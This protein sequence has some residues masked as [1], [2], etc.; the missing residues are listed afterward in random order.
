MEENP[1]VLLDET[2]TVLDESIIWTRNYRNTFG[3]IQHCELCGAFSLE[4]QHH[5]TLQRHLF[6]HLRFNPR[7]I[8]K[9]CKSCHE[10]CH[11]EDD[12]RQFNRILQNRIKVSERNK[13]TFSKT[14]TSRE[15]LEREIS[16]LKHRM[17]RM[18]ERMSKLEQ[19]RGKLYL[20][21]LYA[22]KIQKMQEFISSNFPQFT[23]PEEWKIH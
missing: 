14:R 9:I 7:F 2:H 1:E 3:I 8:I 10:K 6:P 13:P 4:L 23:I 20:I 11:P 12:L 21:D 19:E 16:Q 18:K 22:E 17:K 15:L 5:H